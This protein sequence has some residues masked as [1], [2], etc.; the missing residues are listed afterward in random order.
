MTTKCIVSMPNTIKTQVGGIFV[1]KM[2]NY[3]LLA[4]GTVAILMGGHSPQIPL[5]RGF[6]L[7]KNI[8]PLFRE[9]VDRAKRAA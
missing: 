6:D 8:N 7:V 5:P 3:V 1:S 9:R 2:C 4:S